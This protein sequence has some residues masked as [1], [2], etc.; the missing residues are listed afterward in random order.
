MVSRFQS[1]SPTVNC[2]GMGKLLKWFKS[3]GLSCIFLFSLTLGNSEE[4]KNIVSELSV[5]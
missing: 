4:M 1:L 2:F 3:I 5:A